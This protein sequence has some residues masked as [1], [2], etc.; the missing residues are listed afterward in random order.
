MRKDR[1]RFQARAQRP[2]KKGQ[3]NLRGPSVGQQLRR[4]RR[5]SS[6]TEYS[7]GAVLPLS[8]ADARDLVLEAGGDLGLFLREETE[9]SLV[10]REHI[11]GFSWPVALRVSLQSNH[12][13]AGIWMFGTAL[14]KDLLPTLS[15]SSTPCWSRSMC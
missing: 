10:L 8:L 4:R 12:E 3:D 7:T 11:H 5:R 1:G 13:G 14:P 9:G 6:R 15:G 2:T